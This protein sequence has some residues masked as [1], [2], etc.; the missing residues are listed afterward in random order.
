MALNGL[1]DVYARET[2]ECAILLSPTCFN[3]SVATNIPANRATSSSQFIPI[4]KP[5]IQPDGP[6]NEKRKTY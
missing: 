6:L 2:S 5:V 1:C 4:P 3:T